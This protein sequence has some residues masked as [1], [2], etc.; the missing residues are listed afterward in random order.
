MSERKSIEVELEPTKERGKDVKI[1]VSVMRHGEKTLEGELSDL[2]F[3]KAKKKGLEKEI[4][5]NGIKSYT[6]PFRRTTETLKAILKGIEEKSK[7]KKIFKT[8]VR[9]ELAPPK[10]KHFEKIVE[11]AKRIGAIKGE[12][13][14][15]NYLLSE[16][17]AQEDI[18]KWTSGLAYLIDT[19]RKMGKRLYSRS[20]IELQHI[21]HDI[22]IADFLRKVAILKDKEN[23]RIEVKNLDII[24]GYIKPLEGFIFEIYLD[25]KGSEHL[26]IIFRG[27]EYEVDKEKLKELVDKF[28]R[29]PYKGRTT[30]QNLRIGKE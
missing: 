1:F 23:R 7:S 28:K 10:W 21:T 13:G 8:R 30:K 17:L 16:P 15:L 9:L 11:K 25:D 29:E 18:E 12:S 2:G 22:V 6:S 24:G 14:I 4:P 5:K 26:K 20:E 27:K 3:K 19:Y